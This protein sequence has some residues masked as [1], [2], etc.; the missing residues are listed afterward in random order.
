[1]GHSNL[2]NNR[3]GQTIPNSFGGLFNGQQNSFDDQQLHMS[4]VRQ[5]Q[6]QGESAL[7]ELYRIFDPFN[8]ALSR[9]DRTSYEILHEGSQRFI[10]EIERIGKIEL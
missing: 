9:S 3:L 1:M 2:F 4:Q 10:N 6:R 7:R 8:T 5:Q